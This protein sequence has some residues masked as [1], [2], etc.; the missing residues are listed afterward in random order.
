MDLERLRRYLNVKN[1]QMTSESTRFGRSRVRFWHCRIFVPALSRFRGV[2]L[3]FVRAIFS[4]GTRL[5]RSRRLLLQE[6]RSKIAAA[7]L[8]H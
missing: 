8:T 4:R 7:L 2:R 3:I 6:R 5:V 1:V